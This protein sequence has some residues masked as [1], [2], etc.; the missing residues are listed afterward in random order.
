MSGANI[1]IGLLATLVVAEQRWPW[2][3][4]P[5]MTGPAASTSSLGADTLAQAHMR[6]MRL[7]EHNQLE[8]TATELLKLERTAP[9]DF[10]R[11][12]YDYLLGRV[13]ERLQRLAEAEMAFQRVLA[14]RS[15]LSGYA[16][17]HLAQI[18]RAQGKLSTEQPIL[19]RLIEEHPTSL[20][21]SRAEQ[22]LA[23]SLLESGALGEALTQFEKIAAGGGPSA[24]QA[25]LRGALVK[26]RLSR[27]A[28]ARLDLHRLIE[29][30]R[31]DVALHAVRA[32]DALD[33]EAGRELTPEE[34]LQ[35]ARIY[36]RQ[37]EFA[38]ARAH[39]QQVIEQSTDH[40]ARA[41]AL[42]EIG[43]GYYQQRDFDRARDWFARVHNEFP[44]TREGE[45]GF[46]FIGHALARVGRWREA[47]AQ[48]E[49]FI[50]DYPKSDFLPGAHLNTIDAWRSAGQDEEALQWCR[51]TRERFPGELAAVTA[52]FSQVRIHLARN[53]LTAA[54]ADVDELLRHDLTRTGPGAP[55]RPEVIYLRGRLLEA[56]G[57]FEQ[58]AAAYLS[59]PHDRESYYGQRAT[60][61]LSL[62]ASDRAA[63]KAIED[64]LHAFRREMQAAVRARQYERAKTAALQALRLTGTAA[65]REEIHRRLQVIA[66]HLP[67]Y[68]RLSQL[69]LRK[70][71]RGVLTLAD[72][73]PTDSSPR[74]L[75]SE[76][77]F[78][79]LPDEG[80]Q[81]LAASFGELLSRTTGRIEPT[82]R[83]SRRPRT[84]QSSPDLHDVY[85]LAV[86][87]NRGGHAAEA[88][89]LVETAL[90]PL[91]PP[92]LPLELVPKEFARLLYPTPYAELLQTEIRQRGVDPLFALALMR[93]ESR[94]QPDAK[95][96]AAAR[97]LMQFI[98]ETAHRI[99]P[100]AGLTLTDEEDLYRP[101]VSLRLAGVL[102]EELFGRFPAHP[103]VV[104]AAYNAGED[105]AQ[106]WLS[107]A[108][109][110]D[111][112]RFVLEIGFAE[113]KNYVY[114][115]MTNYWAY[116]RLYGR[117]GQRE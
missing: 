108:R 21:R 107:R 20:L 34:H 117:N 101:D 73:P 28:E 55:N 18:A 81:E 27:Q 82:S 11:N 106:R 17:W 19:R 84:R 52:L 15:V 26:M 79:G 97:G 1:L 92:D 3:R 24:R 63:R 58:A 96:P 37:R 67:A 74:T 71:A 88:L 8:A 89:R 116:Q 65:E 30:G 22:R 109:S 62:L 64:R 4:A 36:Q 56:S 7:L 38:A 42:W 23:E 13:W 6:I 10:R 49:R 14:R 115:V 44:Q 87:Y 95:S 31:D 91:A 75:A 114:R 94:F 51:R 72:R 53:D 46:Y 43:R 5:L 61:R 100:R 112:D 50:A 48:Y 102:L 103:W 59:V 45:Q 83:S 93:Q 105:N 57:R 69:R 25:L 40:R 86:Y 12:N 78:L 70:V 111:P 32:L 90:A 113:T 39:Y 80:A 47:V 66:R 16:L 98:P 41:E 35:R 2:L 85:T 77:L 33:R 110:T 99:A 60:E 9:E 76:L 68:N 29:S 104:A 54:L